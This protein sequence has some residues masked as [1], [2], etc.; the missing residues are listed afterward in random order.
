MNERRVA[1][2]YPTW[3]GRLTLRCMPTLTRCMWLTPSP[4]HRRGLAR[5]SAHVW[6]GQRW[7]SS[8]QPPGLWRRLH[9]T[10]AADGHQRRLDG[11]V[12]RGGGVRHWQ[13][14]APSLGLHPFLHPCVPAAGSNLAGQQRRQEGFGPG[15]V[16]TG[17]AWRRPGPAPG[18]ARG[19]S[20]RACQSPWW[21]DG[22]AGVVGFMLPVV[23]W[24][25]VTHVFFL[26]GQ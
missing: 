25:P 10:A 16:A 14:H 1:A 17:R 18:A 7:F 5:H 21:V 19:V 22:V 12:G 24:G 3:Y 20:E 23:S 2:L 8:L 26:S 15:A 13:Q 9:P 6:H 4:R 11:I